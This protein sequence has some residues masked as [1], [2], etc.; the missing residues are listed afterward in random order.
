MGLL[1]TIIAALAIWIVLWAVGV[2]SLDAF[3]LSLFL[4][5][6]AAA[7]RIFGQYLP[8]NKRSDEQDQ[9]RSGGSWISR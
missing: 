5:L 8:G 6:V 9:P 2:K 7:G 3:L 4:I 1:Y